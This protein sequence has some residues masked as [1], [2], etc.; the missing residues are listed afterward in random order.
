MSIERV[1]GDLVIAA[2]GSTLARYVTDPELPADESPRPFLD[3]LRT[4]G[5]IPVSDRRPAD[6]P[7]HCGLG[8]ALPYV[9]RTN[10]WGGRTWVRE[11]A[12]YLPIG[13]NG[14]MRHDELS[15]DPATPNRLGWSE[16]LSWLDQ[17]GALRA[18][19]RRSLSI[20]LT[21]DDWTVAWNSRVRGEGPEVLAFGSPATHG[22]AGAGYGGLFLRC[23]PAFFGAEVYVDGA[24]GSS[25]GEERM[26]STGRWMA[27]VT[28]TG[29]AATVLMVQAPQQARDEP[30]FARSLEYPGFGPAPFFHDELLLNPASE[31]VFACAVVIADGARDEAWMRERADRT[32]AELGATAWPGRTV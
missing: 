25:S 1:G 27:F 14:R 32:R 6:H 3:A 8:L 10:L 12:E 7:W 5:G 23:A 19:E 22:R 26:A 17:D 16:R 30:W 11:R 18:R 24:S 20:R 21:D 15:L 2:D 4:R 29:P 13:N 9:G 31:S 28:R